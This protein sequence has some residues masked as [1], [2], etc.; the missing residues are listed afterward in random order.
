MII[1]LFDVGLDDDVLQIIFQFFLEQNI[2]G[3]HY[4]FEQAI[5]VEFM[6][7]LCDILLQTTELGLL[8]LYINQLKLDLDTH[9]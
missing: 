9:F 7:I 8:Q 6:I 4:S 5:I 3:L 1:P 2:D